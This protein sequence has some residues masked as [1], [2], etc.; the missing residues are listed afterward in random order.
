MASALI[1]IK[2]IANAGWYLI[3]APVPAHVIGTGDRR[4][5]HGK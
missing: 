2:N 1:A 3:D 5:A 4:V